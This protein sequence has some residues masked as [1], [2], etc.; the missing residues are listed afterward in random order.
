MEGLLPG[1]KGKVGR[2]DRDNRQFIN[3]AF[4][5]LRTGVPWK[6]LPPD[7]G[8]WKNTHRRF[9]RWRDRGIWEKFVDSL[10]GE[11]DLEWVMVDSTHIKVHQHGTG[12]RGGNQSMVRT[13]G[14]STRSYI[15]PWIRL[16]IRSESLQ[17]RVQ[18]RFVNG[19][20]S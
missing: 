4:W 6:E 18:N 14:G 7:L 17:L 1:M 11:P 3:A 2:H 9:S 16:V 19:H 10:C 12:V 20:R 8:D 13:K 5:I 15:W